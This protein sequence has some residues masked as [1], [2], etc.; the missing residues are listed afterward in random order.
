MIFDEINSALS[1]LGKIRNW[2]RTRTVS[3]A[4]SV[5]TRFVR[6]FESHG[7]HRNQI[8]RFIG[9][10]LTLQDVKDDTALLA[11]LSEETLDAACAR[12]A[13]RREWL[14][15]V[16]AQVHPDH[17]FYKHPE[18]FVHFIEDLMQKNPDADMLG[19]LVI[20][21]E[22]DW[23]APALL[24][25]QESV[26]VL[27]EKPIYRYHL[28]NNWGFTYWKARAYLTACVAICWKRNI[29]IHGIS[30]PKETIKQLASGVDLLGWRGEGIWALGHKTWDPED[31]TLRPDK[32]LEG[33]EDRKR[34]NFGIESGLTLWLDLADQGFMD[35]GFGASA[36]Q[37]F[38]QEL[39]KH[40]SSGKYGDFRG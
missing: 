39:E 19:V 6:L 7:V 30:L 28:C 4:E 36:Q 22:R 17:D 27:G 32:F 16:E 5:A 11:K 40:L 2:W 14:D 12:F 9:H 35:S 15:G 38:K 3:R 26:G 10:G 18:K 1:L 24:I 20:P 23:P 25:L 8:P 29:Y 34:G 21:E 33:I 37:D 31:M 13:I